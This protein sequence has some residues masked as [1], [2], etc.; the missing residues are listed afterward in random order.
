MDFQQRRSGGRCDRTRFLPEL[1]QSTMASFGVKGVGGRLRGCAPALCAA[2][3]TVVTV[4]G[5]G[6][7]DQQAPPSR[8]GVPAASGAKLKGLAGNWKLGFA[9]GLA[10]GAVDYEMAIVEIRPG[11]EPKTYTV[12]ALSNS[13]D[14]GAAKLESASA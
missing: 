14:F 7:D 5:C 6:S 3:L 8:P 12:E 1:E 2:I 9:V 4:A 10:E 11:A 13:D